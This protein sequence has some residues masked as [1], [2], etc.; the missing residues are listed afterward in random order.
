MNINRIEKLLEKFYLTNEDFR[1]CKISL[2]KHGYNRSIYLLTAKNGKKYVAKKGN[3]S[4]DIGS[5]NL[6]DVRA[7]SFLKKI[8]CN[9]VPEI[10]YWDNENDFYIESSVGDE[11]VELHELDNKELDTFV[12]QLA[13][14]HSLS[15]EQYQK[16]SIKHGFDE[17][18]IVSPLDNLNVHGFARFEIVKKL[19]PDNYVIDWLDIHLNN[20]LAYVQKNSPIDEAAHLIWGD[21]SSGNLRKQGSTLYFIDWEFSR[22]GFGTELSYIK[23]RSHLSPEKFDYLVSLYAFHSGKTKKELLSGIN[24]TER[25]TRV[26]NIVWT[27]MKWGQSE[28][29]EDEGEYKKLTYERIKLAEEIL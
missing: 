2:I 19:C 22:L 3:E 14:V 6:I 16:F 18:N 11:D 15:A 21:I 10:I 9:F 23:I 29:L 28:T 25:I 4:K 13:F 27:A 24:S 5:S 20:N 8:G 7:Q 12:K 17:P 26:N 1:D